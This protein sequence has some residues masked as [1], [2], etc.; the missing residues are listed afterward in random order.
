MGKRLVLLSRAHI[1]PRLL[2]VKPSKRL[3]KQRYERNK[4]RKR[5]QS[6][7]ELRF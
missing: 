5:K 1:H 4:K 2:A 7:E 3:P 6:R